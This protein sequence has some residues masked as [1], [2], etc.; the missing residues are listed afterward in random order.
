MATLSA[1]DPLYPNRHERQPPARDAARAHPLRELLEREPLPVTPVPYP[2]EART[3][4]RI[5]AHEKRLAEARARFAAKE[6]RRRFM[7]A[8]GRSVAAV[9]KA[10]RKVV[11]IQ[12]DTTPE[13]EE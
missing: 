2:S 11:P 1:D 13:K 12:P 6:A 8:E 7:A 4:A 5:G 10:T 3:A 9:L